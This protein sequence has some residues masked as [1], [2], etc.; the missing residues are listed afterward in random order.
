[1]NGSMVLQV[2][3]R[4]G[5]TLPAKS[6]LLVAVRPYA[7][8]HQTEGPLHITFCRHD[9]ARRIDQIWKS[10]GADE[11]CIR[12]KAPHAWEVTVIQRYRHAQGEAHEAAIELVER[13]K[14]EIGVRAGTNKTL[15][16]FIEAYRE[17][18]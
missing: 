6:K 14:R 5:G 3:S 16:Q 2:R 7:N 10:Y 11:I 12:P 4:L 17:V 9:G 18:F 15:A 1:M 13:I 8:G